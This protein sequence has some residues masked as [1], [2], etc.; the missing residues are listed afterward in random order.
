M[1]G[2]RSEASKRSILFQTSIMRPS[3]RAFDAELVEHRVDVL[4][5]APRCRDGRCRGRGRS[6]RP[7]STSSSVA[8]NAATSW[9]GR[10][11]MNPTVSD[12]IA[13]SKPG[14]A[15]CAHRRVERREQ[16]VLG[17][18]LGA[19]QAV[20]QRRLAGIGIADQRDHR[21]RRPL[22]AARGAARGCVV[23]CSSSRR[24]C[25]MRSRISRR[26]ASIWVSPGPPRKPKPPRWR[27]RWVQLR[28]SRPG[29]VVEMRELDLQPPFAR[30]PPA[31]RKSRGSAR[32]GRS[33]CP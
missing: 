17:H 32:C 1:R 7:R 27:S 10:S 20:E 9:V 30:S 5:P 24:S 22:A 13:L 4:A 26:S 16:Q 25:A 23:T 21:P 3:R 28:T 18:H 29:L 33:P 19:G 2:G 15:I 6:G 11:E 31:R 14:S 12:R 8:R